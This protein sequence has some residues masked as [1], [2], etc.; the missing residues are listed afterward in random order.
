MLVLSSLKLKSGLSLKERQ[1]SAF[2]IDSK[3]E[4]KDLLPLLLKEQIHS[5]LILILP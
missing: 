5:K 2:V 4:E 1:F 3:L